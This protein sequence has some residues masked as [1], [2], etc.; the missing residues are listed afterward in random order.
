MYESNPAIDKGFLTLMEGGER[1]SIELGSFIW[2]GRDPHAPVPVNDQFASLR[3]ARIERADAGYVIRD[4]KSRNGT[5]LNGCKINEAPLHDRDR[6]RVGVTEFVF[7]CDKDQEFNPIF[8]SSRNQTWNEELQRLPAIAQSPYP[9][10]IL[11]P[12]GSGKEVIASMV[13]KFSAR[14]RG[15][16]LGVNCSALTESLAESELFGHKRGSFTGALNERKGA[17]E[18]ARGGT[19][20]LD[21][22][23]DLPLSLQPKLLRALE[24]SE[25]KPLGSD[26][27]IS[28]DVRIV[29]ATNHNLQQRVAEG[30]FRED[31]Y[32]R[33]HILQIRPP[34]L[35]ERR[36]D[37]DTLIS[38][39]STQ[40]S[41]RFSTEALL[42][43][44]K[45]S[46][47]G[48]IRELKNVITRVAALYPGQNITANMLKDLLDKKPD[49]V[50]H[51][52]GGSTV[53]S[54]FEVERGLI[55]DRLKLFGG[56][57]RRVAFELG[58]PKSTLHDRLK[59]YNINPK[60]YKYVAPL[61][62][63]KA[64]PNGASVSI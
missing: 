55:I 37:L 39:F 3:H 31:L 20:F 62:T 13:H 18:S 44:H 57:Q 6:I 33:L 25:V 34:A 56:N 26:I 17:F 24:N 15:P 32:F 42:Q 51:T 22:I 11:G 16:F 50:E 14:S 10:L 1:K 54:L 27:T 12:S 64:M 60:E 9:V 40:N 47:P 41:I 61:S 59:K 30:K 19:L 38:F 36:E 48:N 23:G 35:N 4:L 8:L 28:T 49:I 53:R 2:I 63:P 58:M 46:W 45:Y 21:E 43:F 29:A 52:E 7:S 5:F